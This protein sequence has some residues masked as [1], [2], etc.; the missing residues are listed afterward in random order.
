[1]RFLFCVIAMLLLVVG[2]DYFDDSDDTS[3][4]G[5]MLNLVVD[6]T[7]VVIPTDADWDLIA[8]LEHN[9]LRPTEF[10]IFPEQ[11]Q[12]IITAYVAG[13]H[14]IFEIGSDPIEIFKNKIRHYII[15]PEKPFLDANKADWQVASEKDSGVKFHNHYYAFL[16][17]GWYKP[18]SQYGA[19]G[20]GVEFSEFHTRPTEEFPDPATTTQGVKIGLIDD[21][22][23]AIV[24]LGGRSFIKAEIRLRIYVSR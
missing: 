17:E 19:V 21:L 15:Q 18:D 10:Y 13:K 4:S 11:E 3:G 14:F 2:C 23:S 5:D 20:L 1:M 24:G 8:T 7:P 22:S 12:A 16:S 6:S 9:P